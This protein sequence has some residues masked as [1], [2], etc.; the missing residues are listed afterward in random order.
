M[1]LS[2]QVSDLQAQVAAGQAE[3][4]QLITLSQSEH[5]EL[6]ALS[7]K[8]QAGPTSDDLAALATLTTS[9]QA[10]NAAVTAALKANSA[11]GEPNA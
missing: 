2:K 3:V 5:D 8:I 4:A 11:S 7:A 1:A 9:M 6:V 10:T